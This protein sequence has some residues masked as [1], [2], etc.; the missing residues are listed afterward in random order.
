M[1]EPAN[2]GSLELGLIEAFRKRAE[3]LDL[4]RKIIETLDS[5]PAKVKA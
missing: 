4:M 1:S 3:L 5:E 2:P